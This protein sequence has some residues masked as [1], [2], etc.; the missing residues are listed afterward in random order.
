M[1]LRYAWPGNVRE[2]AAVI[3]RAA[4]LGNGRRLDLA[5]ALGLGGGLEVEVSVAPGKAPPTA[6]EPVRQDQAEPE[7]V[8][9]LSEAMKQHIGKALEQTHGRVEGP[10]GAARLLQLN[11][12]TLRSRMRKLGLRPSDY[13][14]PPADLD[15]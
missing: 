1:L 7:R 2:L 3:E 10:F 13:R 8:L 14:E 11:A 9:P 15:G 12:N 4:I 5:G 6:P